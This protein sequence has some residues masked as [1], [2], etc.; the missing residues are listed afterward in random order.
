M[1]GTRI[2]ACRVEIDFNVEFGQGE[3]TTKFALPGDHPLVEQLLIYHH[4][5][6]LASVKDNPDT[7]GF[8]FS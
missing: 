8:I 2:D 6:L 5:Q 3:Q 7:P 1:R 4:E